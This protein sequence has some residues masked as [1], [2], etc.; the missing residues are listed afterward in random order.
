MTSRAQDDDLGADHPNGWLGLALAIAALA[1]LSSATSLANGFAYDDRWIIAENARVHSLSHPW[2]F[3]RETYWPTTRGAALYRPLTI[4]L[5]AAQWAIGGGSPLVFHIVNVALYVA[6]SVLVLWLALLVLP[7]GAALVAAALF[8]VHPVHVEA[9]GNVVGQSELWTAVVMIAA[10]ALYIRD[11]RDGLPLGPRSTATTVALYVLGML[12]KENAIVL[13]ALIVG[14]EVLLVQDPRPWRARADSLV[15][16][17]VRMGLFAAVFLWVRVRVT[18]DI[19]GDVM[20]PALMGLDFGQRATVMLGLVPEFGRLFLWPAHL[21]ADYSPQQVFVHTSWHP[22]LVSGGL[23]LLCLAILAFVC[24]RRAPVVVFGLAWLAIAIAPVSN[25]L[26][27]TGIL[28]AERTLLVPSIGVVLALAFAT[29]WVVERLRHQ[30]RIARLGAAGIFAVVLTLGFSRSAERQYTWKDRDTV[31]NTLAVDS[32]LSFK[33]HYS[34]GGLLFEQK[35]AIEGEREW[36]YAIALMPGYYGV[37]ADLGHKYRDAH[38]CQAAIPAYQKALAIEPELPLVRAG[39]VACYLELAQ[40]QRARAESR[41]AIADGFYRKAFEY[42]IERADS[43]LM[44]NDS[45]DATNR[46]TGKSKVLKP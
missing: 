15:S 18:G 46:W 21:Y 43:A 45:L 36:R 8:A 27:P 39:M 25:V 3:F 41:S 30:S 32:P 34:Y 4:L 19:G 35:R 10:V 5:Y 17:M 16:L 29:P 37:Y 22:E 42:M 7:R 20:H 13:P 44:A 11:R 12:I 26:L 33:A 23:L 9:V 6:V 38:V 28:I 24:W 40:W 31:F 2:N 1:L 14:A